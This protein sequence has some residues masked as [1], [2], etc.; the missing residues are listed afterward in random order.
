MSKNDKL[1]QSQNILFIT[2]LT[3]L[4]IVLNE[5]NNVYIQFYPKFISFIKADE[6]SI[7]YLLRFNLAGSFFLGLF[8]GPMVDSLGRRKM[9]IIGLGLYLVSAIFCYLSNNFALL[10]LFRFIEGMSGSIISV[11][12]WIILFDKF[13]TKDST[14]ITG[15]IGGLA[16]FFAA[17]IPIF[18]Y[19]ISTI[20]YWRIVFLVIP[21]LIFTSLVIALICVKETLPIEKRKKFV[22]T[23]SF[24]GYS[25]LIK[26]Y[27]FMSQLLIYELSCAIEI[28]FFSN[29][30]IIFI[31]HM[32]MQEE[33]FSFYQSANS[34]SYILFS[35]LSILVINIKGI[36]FTKNIGFYIFA[37]GCIAMFL[38]GIFKPQIDL[39]FISMLIISAGNACMSGFLL[40]AIQIF[41]NLKGTAM[42]LS[43][44]IGVIL[45]AREIRWSQV[46][47]NGT[48]VP[49][50]TIVFICAIITIILFG[51]LQYRAKKAF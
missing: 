36:D 48:I 50:V 28:L 29:A 40:N 23:D 11:V 20:F 14:K 18:A 6:H 12:G 7:N 2:A 17:L 41:P 15:F 3:L 49:T 27:E 4:T 43:G 13:S 30:S 21:L 16:T 9:F 1:D 33:A 19:W 39:I 34:A 24:K 37:I 42:S 44:T 46:F 31:N 32:G 5:E 51:V 47:F 26:K 45:A 38:C 25:T 35:L 22:F 8:I 10:L